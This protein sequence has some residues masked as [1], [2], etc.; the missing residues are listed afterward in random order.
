MYGKSPQ[1]AR[2]RPDAVF[3]GFGA[4][5]RNPASALKFPNMDGIFQSPLE[6]GNH[7]LLFDYPSAG[8]CKWKRKF[9]SVS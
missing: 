2:K 5:S 6:R 8:Q 4:T 7:R 9:N 1:I 3:A